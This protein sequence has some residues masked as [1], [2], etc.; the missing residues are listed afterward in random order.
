M[1]LFVALAERAI[2]PVYT[3]AHDRHTFVRTRKLV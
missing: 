3:A 2:S 1:R